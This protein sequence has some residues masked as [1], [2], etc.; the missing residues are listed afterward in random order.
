MAYTTLFAGYSRGLI[1]RPRAVRMLAAIAKRTIAGWGER[2]AISLGC[3]GTGALG[4]EATY[5]RVEELYE[6]ARVAASYGIST[7][8]AFDLGGM[9][10]RGGAEVWL[11]AFAAGANDAYRRGNT[12]DPSESGGGQDFQCRGTVSVE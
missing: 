10:R 3:V 8:S 11:D 5:A 7:L 1:D 9:V 12:H 6:D 2:A 4:N